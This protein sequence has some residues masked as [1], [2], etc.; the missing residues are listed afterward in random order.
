MILELHPFYDHHDVQPGD[1]VCMFRD[2]HTNMLIVEVERGPGAPAGEVVVAVPAP[3]AAA[4]AAAAA[5]EI[6]AAAAAALAA[7]QLPGKRWSHHMRA[8]QGSGSGQYRRSPAVSEEEVEEV[9]QEDDWDYSP[10]A[11]RRS[12]A[13]GHGVHG[14]QV[15]RR[16]LHTAQSG[17]PQVVDAGSDEV[18]RHPLLPGWGCP[19]CGQL[20]RGAAAA[21]GTAAAAAATCEKRV[22][23]ARP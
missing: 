23:A 22:S 19:A 9:E 13:G 4:A 11:A 1:T 8:G 10:S 12:K 14:T 20:G 5:A 15:V 17:A 2:L 6:A 7:R 21:N 16:A 18:G 3:R